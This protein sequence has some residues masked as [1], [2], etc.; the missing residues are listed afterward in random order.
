MQRQLYY[1]LKI[2]KYDKQR[3][4]GKKDKIKNNII[5]L[6]IDKYKKN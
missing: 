5:N 4:T 3:S 2:I 1:I 6:K